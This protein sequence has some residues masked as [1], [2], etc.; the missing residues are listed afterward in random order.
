MQETLIDS[1]FKHLAVG[2]QDQ[3]D[4][5]KIKV[6][7]IESNA[8]IEIDNKRKDQDEAELV[9][10]EIKFKGM[11]TS[12]MDLQLAGHKLNGFYLIKTTTQPSGQATNNKI[13]T[14]FCDFQP[15]STDLNGT[16]HI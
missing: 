9:N 8:K 16:L 2:F 5:L 12:C 4:D 15:N 10:E 14:V 13:E 1:R 11:P 6:V 7:E 3:I